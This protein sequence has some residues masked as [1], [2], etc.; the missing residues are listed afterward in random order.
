MVRIYR[1]WKDK[2]FEILAFPCN[3]FFGQESGTPEEI[4]DF[5]TNKFNVEFPLLEKVEVNGE[6]THPVFVFL[7]NNSSLFDRETMTA[8]VIPWNFAKFFVDPQGKVIQF[9]KPQEKLTEVNAF[10]EEHMNK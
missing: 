1:K 7:R 5:V 4:H 2:G 9:Y 10:I 3:Q 8:Q 6:N